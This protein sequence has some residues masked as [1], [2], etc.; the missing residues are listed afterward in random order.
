MSTRGEASFAVPKL[1]V[2]NKA[3]PSH[4][5]EQC[6]CSSKIHRC[7]VLQKTE[8]CML[9]NLV[10]NEKSYKMCSCLHFRW[11]SKRLLPNHYNRWCCQVQTEFSG[12][13]GQNFHLLSH[14]VCPLLLPS[15][16]FFAVLCDEVL[17]IISI[18]EV[19]L[20]K[21]SKVTAH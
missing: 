16:H 8:L 6:F 3:R 19:K 18:E 9:L 20:C 14:I 7:S 1:L 10:L 2:A 17:V 12:Q 4:G 5:F 15:Q 13:S 21:Y 11:F